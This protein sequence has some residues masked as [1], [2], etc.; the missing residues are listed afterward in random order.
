MIDLGK[1]KIKYNQSLD[2]FGNEQHG[3]F[4]YQFNHRLMTV[5]TN[6]RLYFKI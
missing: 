2:G 5:F 1:L 3:V 6:D 4:E